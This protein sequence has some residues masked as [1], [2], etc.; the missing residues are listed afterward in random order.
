M[1]DA[2]WYPS[3]EDVVAIHDDVVSEYADTGSGVR[4][5]GGSEFALEYVQEGGFGSAPE[6]VHEKAYHLL[7]LLVANHPFVDAN[8]RTAL[9]TVAVFYLL[10]GYRFGYDDEMRSLLKR[11]GTDEADV[12]EAATIDYLRSHTETVDLAGELESWREDLVRDGLD[13]LVGESSD[14]TG[15]R[16]DRTDVATEDGAESRSELDGVMEDVGRELVRRVAAADRDANREIYDA[17]E[18]E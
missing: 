8:K 14:R 5:R 13:E 12:D 11:F 15:V 2:F 16:D 3:V 4:D 18:H 10:N 7:R 6:T 1:A 9:D 17:L